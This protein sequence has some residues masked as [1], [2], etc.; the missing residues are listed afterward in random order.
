MK[1]K[2]TQDKQPQ[3]KNLIQND[4]DSIKIALD[5]RKTSDGNIIINNHPY[6]DII[7]SPSRYKVIVFPKDHVSDEVYDVQ[8]DYLKFLINQGAAISDSMQGGSTY[9][10]FEISYPKETTNFDPLKIVLLVTSKFMINERPWL[11]YIQ[12]KDEE[13]QRRLTEPD[14][15]ESTEFG[16]IPHEHTKGS[17][18]YT[19]DPYSM[20]Y[21]LEEGKINEQNFVPGSEFNKKQ[22]IAQQISKEAEQDLN[23]LLKKYKQQFSSIKIGKLDSATSPKDILLAYQLLNRL[24]NRIQKDL[25]KELTKYRGVSEVI[26]PNKEARRVSV[27]LTSHLPRVIQ[28]FMS[29]AF[30]PA[31]FKVFANTKSPSPEYKTLYDFLK[32]GIDKCL[33]Q[34]DNESRKDCLDNNRDLKKSSIQALMGGPKSVELFKKS[35]LEPTGIAHVDEIEKELNELFEPDAFEAFQ[36]EVSRI[37]SEVILEEPDYINDEEKFNDRYSE[38]LA[39]IKSLGLHDFIKS[40][41]LYEQ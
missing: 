5:I 3:K 35:L 41:D 15:E 32:G 23:F 13:E 2:L 9:G 14:E 22:T 10:S 36:Q 20:N 6:I 31:F 28:Q 40:R 11:E 25:T 12:K 33:Q 29:N 21:R 1:I 4:N 38:L 24:Q 18:Q 16:E 19:Y 34:K 17:M 27:Q 37:V 8:N 26:D 7:I 39:K 30:R